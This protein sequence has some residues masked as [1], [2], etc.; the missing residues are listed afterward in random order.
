[1]FQFINQVVSFFIHP[2]LLAK[3]GDYESAKLHEKA[4]TTVRAYLL[5]SVFVITYVIVFE[6][7]GHQISTIKTV[8]NIL[9]SFACLGTL[10]LIKYRGALIL[11]MYIHM[12][13]FL[14][15]LF[16]SAYYSGGIY[17]SDIFWVVVVP[18]FTLMYNDKRLGILIF[19][20]S[21]FLICLLYVLELKN[22][23]NFRLDNIRIGSDYEFYNV[24]SSL[25]F[26]STITLFYVNSAEKIQKQLAILRDKEVRSI[27]SKFQYIIENAN[28]IIS[29][30]DKNIEVTYISPSVKTILEYD[31]DEMIGVNCRDL[32]GIEATEYNQLF[33]QECT[34]KYGKKV[35][36][37][38]TM[39]QIYDE[40]GTGDRFIS[41][42]RDVTASVLENKRINELRE[43]IANDF[44]DEIGNK[45]AAITLNANVLGVKMQ[46]NKDLHSII[47]KIQETSKSLYQNSRDFIWSID[48]KSDNLG[49]IYMYIRDFGDDFFSSLPINFVA[50]S[51]PIQEFENIKLPMYSGRHIILICT[52]IFTNAAK[53]SNC[54][55]IDFSFT[56]SNNL[57]NIIIRD[58]GKGFN[59][60]EIK[61]GKGLRSM[62][63]RAQI[64][65]FNH[66]VETSSSG[67]TIRLFKHLS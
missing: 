61:N 66:E 34:T 11:S 28:E 12:F 1:M 62:K 40:L 8:C 13:A 2:R 20:I 27:D 10:L 5:T 24:I 25:I 32:F 26:T 58:N 17:S 64:I 15:L 39:N 65:N 37:E 45:L 33:I 16:I 49:E 53:H 36:L 4:K 18:I 21:F 47:N 50:D 31:P 57:F 42:A 6:L 14:T 41:L 22:F 3:E 35:W 52:E 23:G 46:D 55:T 38:I 54:D 29:L 60:Q 63:K 67:T 48:S 51:S 30:H 56:Y 7:M 43:Q 59:E 9:A 19:I 44:H